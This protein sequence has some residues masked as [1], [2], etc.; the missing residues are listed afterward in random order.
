MPVKPGWTYLGHPDL[1][2]EQVHLRKWQEVHCHSLR[3]IFYPIELGA[4]KGHEGSE[5]SFRTEV[6]SALDWNGEETVRSSQIQKY[7]YEEER[8]DTN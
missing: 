3:G 6:L 7:P 2:L 4:R 1:R 8:K 5:S